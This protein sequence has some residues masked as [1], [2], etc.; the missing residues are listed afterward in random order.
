MEIQIAASKINKYAT[1]ESGDTLEAVERPGGG[2]SIVLADGQ[3]SGKS[4]KRISNMVV[5][6]TISLLAEGVRD[7]AA[8][9]ASADYLFAERHGKVSAT[10]NILSVDLVTRSLV[11][12]RNNP[13]PVLYIQ[14]GNLKSFGEP[15][16]PVGYYRNTR[17]VINELHL[18]SGLCV[19]V[20]TDGLTHAGSRDG[21]SMLISACFQSLYEA[22]RNNTRKISDGILE[23]ALGLDKGRPVDDISVVVLNVTDRPED[24]VR[25]M[26]IRLPLN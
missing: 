24:D 15:S 26:T 5:R 25:R 2:L 1:S 23:E 16:Q 10:L 18:Q 14:E 7:G 19:L 12:S 6:K 20:Y 9:R 17:P 13:A 3:R 4:A 22:N 21:N 8:A 11:V